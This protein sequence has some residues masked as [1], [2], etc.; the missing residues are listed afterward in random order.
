[1]SHPA[2]W[3]WFVISFMATTNAVCIIFGIEVRIISCL[4]GACLGYVLA[5]FT[6]RLVEEGMK[7]PKPYGRFSTPEK[8]TLFSFFWKYLPIP[9]M[10]F[11]FLLGVAYLSFP[12]Q[13]KESDIPVGWMFILFL[14]T[15]FSIRNYIY[16]TKK[17][18][19]RNTALFLYIGTSSLAQFGGI[20]DAYNILFF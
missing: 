9:M 17:E 6:V 7:V 2:F 11:G 15:N 13:A 3:Y 20:D 12:A 14:L 19:E 8:Q 5:L 18:D 16:M 1:M 4:A 10:Y